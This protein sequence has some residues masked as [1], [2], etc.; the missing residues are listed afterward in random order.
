LGFVL[1]TLSESRIREIAASL[2]QVTAVDESRCEMHGLCPIHGEKNPSFSYNF[3]KDSYHC[4]SCSAGGDLIQLWCDVNGKDRKEGFREFCETFGIDPGGSSQAGGAAQGGGGGQPSSQNLEA[5][6]EKFPKPTPEWLRK[7]E[8]IRGWSPKYIE[9]LDLRLQSHYFNSKTGKVFPARELTRIAIP[10]RD[11]KG[12]LR[13]IRGYQP[14]ASQNKMISWGKDFGSSRLFPARPFSKDLIILCEG[15]PDTMCA[16]SNGFNAITQTAKLK[17]WPKGHLEIFKGRDVVIAYDAD[18]PG[19]TYAR[20]AADSLL[21]VAKSVRLL[22]WPDYM[23]GENGAYPENHG[24]DLTDFFVRHNKK[25][26]DLNELIAQAKPYVRGEEETPTGYLQFFQRGV[27]DRLSFKSR[28][29]AERI[30]SD[31]KLLSDPE[32][33]LLYRWNGRIWEIYDEEHIKNACIKHLADESQKSRVEDAV[34]QV[35]ILSTIPH[36]RHINDRTEW[37]CVKNGILNMNTFTLVSPD[38][39]FYCTYSLPVEFNPD[40]SERCRRW[41][42]YLIDSVQT[43]DAI[44]QLQEFAGYC[45]IRTAKYQKCLLLIGPGSDGKS[46]FLNIMKEMIGTE[47]CAAVSFADLEDQFQRSSLYDKLLNIST[48]VGAKAMES[49]FFKAIVSGDPINAAF[50]H[51]DV[52]TF[53]P[54]CKLAFASNRLPRVLDNSE[55]FFRRILPIRFKRQFLEDNDPNLFDDLMKEL[56]EIFSWS[57]VGL[58]RLISQNRFTNCDETREL[59]MEYRRINN[60]VLCYVEDRCLI[61]EENEVPKDQLY[62]D[63]KSYCGMN[64]YSAMNNVN[65]FRELYVAINNIHQYRPRKGNVREN[66]LKGIKLRGNE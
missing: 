12:I 26:S 11:E 24:Q 38:P 28:L 15:E 17:K 18:Q 45:L 19:Q 47:N 63:Y 44:A 62:T 50:K 30:L 29:L 56:S 53:S 40:S 34:Y 3:K 57:I 64:G 27:N 60:P 46:T 55:G 22:E 14:G 20:F 23:R 37:I 31:V 35:R 58:H 5:I 1:K 41:E 42:Q 51:K 10:V 36:G 21:P 8:E 61:G 9:I 32:T 49:P 52:F 39:D 59:M 48:E 2:F 7:M 65:F 66:Y 13:N 33:G 25:P 6:F 4:F 54:H 16:L 43:P